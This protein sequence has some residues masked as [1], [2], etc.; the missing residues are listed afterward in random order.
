VLASPTHFV[1]ANA[2]PILIIHGL[3]DTDVPESQS[4]QLYNMLVAAGDQT[5]LILVDNM[6]HMFVH[7]GSQP[8]DPSLAQIAQDMLGFFAK[9]TAGG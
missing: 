3:N 2:P 5:Q 4:V 8:I 6:G 1:V 9:Y 7:V